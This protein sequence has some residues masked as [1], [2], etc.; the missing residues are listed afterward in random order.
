MCFHKIDLKSGYDANQHEP[1]QD[2]LHVPR[3]PFIR[4]ISKKIKKAFVGL[5]TKFLNVAQKGRTNWST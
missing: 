2:P 1:L 4:A 5:I 3:G